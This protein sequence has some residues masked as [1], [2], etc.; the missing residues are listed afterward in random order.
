MPFQVVELLLDADGT[1]NRPRG[2]SC[3]QR[4]RDYRKLIPPL[5]KGAL[6]SRPGLLVGDRREP[7]PQ[8]WGFAG[9]PSLAI[10][11]QPKINQTSTVPALGLSVAET[12]RANR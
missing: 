7:R 10:T 8:P 4:P 3:P 6:R 9:V 1:V 11:G 12:G 5:Q 2:H